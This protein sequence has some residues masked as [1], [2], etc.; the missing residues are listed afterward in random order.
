M[1]WLVDWLA[2][3]AVVLIDGE[4]VRDTI[5]SIYYYMLIDIW[6]GHVNRALCDSLTKR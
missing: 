3:D 2:G 4:G 6:V 1:Y 5:G